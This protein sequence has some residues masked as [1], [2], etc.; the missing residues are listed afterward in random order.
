MSIICMLLTAAGLLAH[1]CRPATARRA[2]SKRAK[3]PH[4][5]RVPGSCHRANRFSR[6]ERP[7]LYRNLIVVRSDTM[8]GQGPDRPAKLLRAK[9]FFQGVG[10]RVALR[11]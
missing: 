2:A 11:R 1:G 10:L 4:L 8:N 9:D 3:S 5:V 7:G 6:G